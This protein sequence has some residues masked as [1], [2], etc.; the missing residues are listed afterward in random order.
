MDGEISVDELAELIEDDGV[1]VVDIRSPEAYRRGHI[2]GSEN[3]PF[4]DL[5]DRIGELRGEDRV[6]AVCPQGKASVQAAR[7]VAA[8]DG[9]DGRVESLAEGLEGWQRTGRDLAADDGPASADD[10]ESTEA[11]PADGADAPF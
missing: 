2:P 9:F 6:V 8:Y 10:E 11:E 4:G 1:R 3:V 7:L 5:P